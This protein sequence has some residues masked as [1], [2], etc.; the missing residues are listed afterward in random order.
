MAAR[1]EEHDEI[2]TAYAMRAGGPGWAN[3]PVWVV[4]RSRLDGSYREE[5]L[6]PDDLTAEAWALYD[7]SE[8]THKAMRGVVK[9]LVEKRKRRPRTAA[10]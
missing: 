3:Q 5:C 10:V 8:A 7:I 2:I 9:A 1:F 6:Q 4:V